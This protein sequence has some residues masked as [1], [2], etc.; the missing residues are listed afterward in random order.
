MA[1]QP[2]AAAEGSSDVIAARMRA[3]MVR[4]PMAVGFVK[5]AQFE[6]VSEQFNHLFGHGD[7][8]DL[9]GQGTRSVQVSDPAHHSLVERTH[10]AFVGGK[11]LD[12][13]VEFVRRDGS[14][15]WGRL[16]ATPVHWDQ[17]AGEALWIVDAHQV[18]FPACGRAAGFNGRANLGCLAG[19]GTDVKDDEQCCVV[20]RRRDA[21]GWRGAVSGH[22]AAPPPTPRETRPR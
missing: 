12:D 17:P 20:C 6:V 22:S 2:Q 14:R 5:N 18:H 9:A 4:A 7:D 19:T 21:S 16:Q 1:T 13:E 11:P 8:T 3:L 10:A 15:F